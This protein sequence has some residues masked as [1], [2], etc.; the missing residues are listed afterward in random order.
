MGGFFSAPAKPKPPPPPPAPPAVQA[1]ATAV[2]DK[3]SISEQTG[4]EQKRRRLLS[5][6]AQ[7]STGAGATGRKLLG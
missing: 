7:A 2:E 4:E 5:S 1:S 6:R 3:L